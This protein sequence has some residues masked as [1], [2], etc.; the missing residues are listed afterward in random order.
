[1]QPWQDEQLEEI[2]QK[3]ADF[4]REQL[5]G[6]ASERDRSGE[7]GAAAQGVPWFEWQRW[8]G[9]F[10]RNVRPQ[11][12]VALIWNHR[13]KGSTP[14]LRGYEQLLGAFAQG[15]PVVDDKQIDAD[16]LCIGCGLCR[17]V[18]GAKA[19]RM[20]ATPAGRENPVVVTPR[21]RETNP[22]DATHWNRLLFG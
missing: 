6:D 19:I 1:M 3:H 21:L 18:A 16:G 12:W 22:H 2:R 10:A 20:V 14:F 15:Y 4:A 11:G 17:S 13:R 7:L 5:E 9:E 8:R